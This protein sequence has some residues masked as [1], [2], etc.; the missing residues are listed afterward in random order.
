MGLM[1]LD[2][3]SLLP[4]GI[5]G[6]EDL[7]VYAE[8]AVLGVENQDYFY[9]NLSE[10]VPI[11]F[12]INLPVFHVLDVLSFQ[13]EYYGTPYNNFGAYNNLSLPQWTD[14]QLRVYRDDWKWSVYARK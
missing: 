10:R 11:M 14:N 2:F 12:G 5:L 9:E 13:M 7:R 6:P 8:A 4:E 1:S 3:G